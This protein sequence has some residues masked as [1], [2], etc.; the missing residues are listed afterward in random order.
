MARRALAAAAVLLC[1]AACRRNEQE[2]AI[3]DAALKAY[4]AEMRAGIKTFHQEHGRYPHS[5]EELVP[6]HLRRIPVDPVTNSHDTWRL[7]TEE[8]VPQNADFTTAAAKTQ[9]FV[10]DVHSGAGAPY[11]SW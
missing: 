10:L 3:R 1:L 11:S 6:K 2:R 4:L 8:V 9:T 7:T 5:L